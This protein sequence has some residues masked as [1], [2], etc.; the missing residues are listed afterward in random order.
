MSEDSN[1]LKWQKANVLVGMTANPVHGFYEITRAKQSEGW[2]LHSLTYDGAPIEG[3][4][5][6]IDLY[7]LLDQAQAHHQRQVF[8]PYKER[9][10]G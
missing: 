8:I 5:N 6:N 9:N 3:V 7:I 10:D 2:W 1:I 4:G